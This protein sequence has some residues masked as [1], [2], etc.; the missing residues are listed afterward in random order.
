MFTESAPALAKSRQFL[1]PLPGYIPVYIRPGN[2]P[3]EDINLDLAEA[4]QSYAFKQGRLSSARSLSQILTE[5]DVK[6]EN[7]ISSI[8]LDDIKLESPK[9]NKNDIIVHTNIQ[10]IPKFA[11]L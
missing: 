6:D 3:L 9:S 11:Q 8:A 4:F 1:P 10:K 2:T 7:D 5:N